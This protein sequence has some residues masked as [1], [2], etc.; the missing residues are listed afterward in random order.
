MMRTLLYLLYK[1][2]LVV[3]RD[4]A[5][6]VMLFLLPMSLVLIMTNLQHKSF[7]AINEKGIRLI[8][9]NLDADSLGNAIIHEID[10]SGFFDLTLADGP[11]SLTE[12]ELKQAVASG[13]FQ[14]GLVIPEG[15][16][17]TIRRRVTD[18]VRRFFLRDSTAT[19]A[20]DTVAVRVFIDP[21]TKNSLLSS[22][23]G[24]I[25]EFTGKIET[26]IMLNELTHAINSRLM[27]PVPNLNTMKQE[28]VTYREQYVARGDRIVIPNAVQHNVPAWTLFAM[29]FIVIPFASS[30]IKERE[31][32]NLSRLLTMPA[33][34]A[35]IMISRVILYLGGCS[36][37]FL[38]IVLMGVSFFP[39]LNLPA[40]QISGNLL[41]LTLMALAS[42][43]A[44][45][46]YG[47]VVGS[48]ARTHQQAAIF[49]SVSVVILAALGGIWVPVFIMPHLMQ[50][51]SG[52]SPLNW[53]LNGF[54]DIFI[55]Q[56]GLARIAPYIAKLVFFAASCMA[57]AWGYQ[58]FRISAS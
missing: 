48:I 51:I 39:Q 40:L 42:S 36:L 7:N 43:L 49:A 29:F 26:R 58:K 50:V 46:G 28:V 37:Q 2:Y 17:E 34:Y 45:I 3:V 44:A 20:E 1:D 32:G 53:G 33:S 25:R 9:L 38:A 10:N 6:L 18:N 52:F 4:R 16:T 30:M 55:R 13:K 31:D 15:A 54:Y 11:E 23:Q 8:A 24:S 35:S 19:R 56:D 12:E 27:F 47:I 14:I 22:L 5:A 21:V 41:N 57:L